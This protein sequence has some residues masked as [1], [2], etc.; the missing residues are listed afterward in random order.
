M[1]LSGNQLAGGTLPLGRFVLMFG[2]SF[3][4]LL[5]LRD[6]NVGFSCL[7]IHFIVGSRTDAV[8]RALPLFR[9][10]LW[11]VALLMFCPNGTA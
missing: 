3:A 6:W 1:F 7:S 10:E 4:L 11:I 9:M 8:I 5:W 2:F